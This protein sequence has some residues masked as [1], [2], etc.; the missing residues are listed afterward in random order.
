MNEQYQKFNDT[1]TDTLN[2]PYGSSSIPASGGQSSSMSMD[3]EGLF[4]DSE[5]LTGQGSLIV[6]VTL[7]RGAIPVP[8]AKV[9][10]ST[11]GDNP[12]VISEM[13]T[14]ESGRTKRL[15]LP[16]PQSS[17]SQAPGSKV[18]PYSTYNIKIESDGYYTEDAINVPIFDKVNSIQPIGL[19]P[20]PEGGGPQSDIVITESEPSDL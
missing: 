15:F 2:R 4:T 14:D 9:T 13:Y 6:Q 10:V 19:D 7:A 12:T 5:K 11:S 20:L 18:R 3:G 16:A 17:F 8:G 1:L